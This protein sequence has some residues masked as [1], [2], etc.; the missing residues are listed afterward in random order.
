MKAVCAEVSDDGIEE[1][2]QNIPKD[3]E[4]TYE[5][6]MD[7]IE[8][9]PPA[10]R[11]LAKKAL[12]FVA[13]AREPLS[14]DVLALAIATKDPAQSLDRLRSSISTEK[15]ILHACGNLLTINMNSNIRCVSFVHFSVHEYLTTSRPKLLHTLF[16]VAE[17]AHREI[18]RMC[19]VFLLILYS[20]IQDY[21]TNVESSFANNYILPS[22]P[23]HLLA[24]NLYSLPSNDELINLSLLFFEKGP[25]LLTSCDGNPPLHRNFL[26]F[27]PSVLALMFNLPVS[28]QSYDPQA[29]YGK[30]LYHWVLTW[31]H[32]TANG[33]Y[34]PFVQVSDD[35]LAMHYATDQLDS[36]AACQRLYAYGYPIE[37]SYCRSE[38]PLRMVR[39]QTLCPVGVPALCT[40]TPLYL[41]KSGEVARFLLSRG[42]SVNRSGFPNL[43]GHVAQRGNTQ[44]IQLLLDYGAE[45]KEEDQGRA[46][47]ILASDGK[48]E[49]IR[50]LFNNGV[51]VNTRSGSAL[52][53]A[54]GNGKVEAMR[55]LLDNGADVHT[56]GGQYGS[57]LQ[58]AIC[59]DKPEAIR[60][61]LYRG[62]DPYVQ[63]GLFGNALEAAAGNGKVKAMQALLDQG[64]DVN[65]GG[66]RF[67]N[68]LQA[69]AS[70]GHVEAIGLLLDHR[71]DANVCG[72]EFG[73]ALQ[74]AATMGHMEALRL[75]LDRGADVNAQDP[76]YGTALQA[77][78]YRG[79][80][81]AMQL[82]LDKGAEVNVQGGEYGNA[83]QA[84]ARQGNVGAMQ[85][86]LDKGADIH[87][88]GKYGSALQAAACQGN[89]AAVQLLLDEG[90]DVHWK[91]GKYGSALQA[92]ASHGKVEVLRLLRDMGAIDRSIKVDEILLRGNTPEG[93]W[94]NVGLLEVETH[95]DP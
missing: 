69:A 71:V 11:E 26:T 87:A 38:I 15:I 40:L 46:L 32:E 82:L 70:R 1:T 23:F 54:A 64:V 56:L 51:D 80:I 85:L 92:A 41:V 76:T 6:I 3:I 9:K 77:E 91:G 28:Y 42:A 66:G 21:S 61:L 59:N 49:A 95:P 44:V 93:K 24:G 30:Q 72:G 48:V 16:S 19:M 90:A 27:S 68:A 7:I 22:L 58:A 53:A 83:L 89:I 73:N 60:L 50:F 8:K 55:F 33:R 25:P 35:R 81:E 52:Q 45:Q 10:Q 13:Y 36:V 62:A 47:E 18:A 14:I 57:A 20:H 88:K 94:I 31:V 39:S 65:V 84:A 2:L 86:L 78:A 75:L 79:N 43:L 37:Y 4:G 34:L 63:S 5:R 12:L 17:M 67:G 29:L 74:A